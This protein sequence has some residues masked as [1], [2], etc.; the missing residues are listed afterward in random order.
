MKE[1]IFFVKY[2]S[3]NLLKYLIFAKLF[4]L[5]VFYLQYKTIASF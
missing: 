3:N 1:N 5:I 2:I 4:D